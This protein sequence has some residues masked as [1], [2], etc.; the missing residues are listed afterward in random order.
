MAGPT[1]PYAGELAVTSPAF[2]WKRFTAASV[3][4]PKYPVTFPSGYIAGSFARICWSLVT[5]PAVSASVLSGSSVWVNAVHEEGAG[6]A[7]AG[8]VGTSATIGVERPNALLSAE[9]VAGPSVPVS[10]SPLLFWNAFRDASV[11][12]FAMPDTGHVASDA[13]VPG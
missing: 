2:S 7:A 12:T 9:R 3:A 8:V 11:H 13:S 5:S 10:S 6:V 4:G 1:S